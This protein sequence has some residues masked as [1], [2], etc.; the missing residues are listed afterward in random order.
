MGLSPLEGTAISTGTFLVQRAL[1]RIGAHSV[2]SPASPESLDEGFIYLNSLLELWL[3][4]GIDIG[5][6][7]ISAIGDEVNEPVDA[8]SGIINNLALELAP[9]FDNGK[10]V[11]S[12]NLINAAQRDFI[13]VKNLYQQLSIP[14]KVYSST[15]PAGQG[16]QF[17]S[18]GGA[19]VPVG[20]NT[21]GATGGILPIFSGGTNASDAPTALINLGALPTAGGIMTGNLTLSSSLTDRLGSPGALGRILSSTVTGVE[22]ILGGGDVTAVGTPVDGQVSVWTGANSIEG[23]AALTFDTTSD[24]FVIGAS[25]NLAFGAIVI[26][27]DAAGVMTLRNIDAIDAIT[28]NT[29]EA[30]IDSLVNLVAVGA[31]DAGSITSGF[32][33]IDIGSSP[34]TT[35]GLISGGALTVTGTITGPSGSWDVGGIDIATGDSFAINSTDVLTATALGNSVVS[36]I[37]TSVGALN[38]GSITSGFGSINIGSSA[39]DTTG[40]A[41][42]GSLRVTGTFADTSGDVGT[43]G[44]IL[45]STATGT[46]WITAPGGGD[47]LIATYDPAAISE[48]LVGLVATQTLTNKTLED[49]SNT[50]R[51]DE[52]HQEVRNSSGS[53]L[54]KGTPVFISGFNVGQGLPEV[55]EADANVAASMPCIG[56]IETDILNNA[57]G[58]VIEIGALEGINTSSFS[59]GDSLYVST[60]PGTLTNT[61]PTAA[62][63]EVQKIAVVLR[64]HASLGVIEIFGAGRS[65]DIPNRMSDAIV[66][67][68]DNADASKV[69][70]FESSGITTATT[71]TF[72]FPDKDGVLATVDDVETTARNADTSTALTLA[73]TDGGQTVTMNNA[74]A[75]VLTIPTNASV[76][77][78][79]S[80]SNSAVINVLQIGAGIT[81]ITA[82]TGV[83]LNGVSAGSGAISG[84]FG[85]VSLM[86][87]AT[88]TWIATGAIG[89]VV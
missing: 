54:T 32:G 86:K 13:T 50:I 52:I 88:N 72:T 30:A 80:T 17:R 21:G 25:G 70:A 68:H 20:G 4:K 48:Q 3:S 63:D 77:F 11:A 73:L 9:S 74:S 35:T 26:L 40:L 5:T 59:V 6:V 64:S 84:Q 1:Q 23:D 33:S 56:I 28:E 41:T 7:P 24:T 38:S 47:M 34:F 69:A 45:S 16:N 46:N 12:Q 53:T 79:F 65:N 43:S 67:I 36:S 42:F 62:G 8:R 83:T 57:N 22:W 75:N 49:F 66:R 87:V 78:P 71:R 44:Q 2:V 82:D 89:A 29:L 31:L 19:T 61:R 81:T 55:D 58:P 60:T 15:L 14:E 18:Y 51:A 27:D 10:A 76:A 37:L 85:G 39:L